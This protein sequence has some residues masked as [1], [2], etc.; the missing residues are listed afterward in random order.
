M[1]KSVRRDFEISSNEQTSVTSSRENVLEHK[2]PKIIQ[3][4]PATTPSTSPEISLK[5]IEDIV[6]NVISQYHL[7][8]DHSSSFSIKYKTVGDNN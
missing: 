1:R 2:R 8:E 4:L 7:P 6:E 5:S 3:H